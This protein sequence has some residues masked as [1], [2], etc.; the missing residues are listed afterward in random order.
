MSRNIQRVV[1]IGSGTMGGGIAA[2][3]ANAGI[4]VHLLDISPQVVSAGFERMK[5]SKPPAFFTPETADLVTIGSLDRPEDV[6]PVRHYGIEGRVGWLDRI[7]A[8]PAETTEASMSAERA[9]K[10]VNHQHPD[11]DTDADWTPL[12]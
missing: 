7:D 10:F 6:P 1:V 8:L 12:R 4:P 11:H 3:F 2:H 9:G 5:K